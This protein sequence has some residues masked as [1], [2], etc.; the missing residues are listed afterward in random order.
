MHSFR[1]VIFVVVGG[2]G[3]KWHLK[4]RGDHINQL[5]AF[6]TATD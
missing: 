3:K 5:N 4:M 1:A 2:L 6:T